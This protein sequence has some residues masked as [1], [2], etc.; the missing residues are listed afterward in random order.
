ME[1][2]MKKSL[3]LVS[4]IMFSSLLKASQN[5]DIQ[6]ERTDS[7]NLFFKSVTKNL[8]TL[9]STF[10]GNEFQKNITF[11]YGLFLN[12]PKIRKDLKEININDM[13]KINYGRV[14]SYYIINNINQNTISSENI[15]R[16]YNFLKVLENVSSDQSARQYLLNY[17][18]HDG[19][20]GYIKEYSKIISKLKTEFM[21]KILNKVTK[22]AIY[23]SETINSSTDTYLLNIIDNSKLDQLLKR[24]DSNDLKKDIFATY[25]KNTVDTITSNKKMLGSEFYANVTY[26]LEP[27]IKQYASLT[28]ESLE[29]VVDTF[30][31]KLTKFQKLLNTVKKFFKLPLTANLNQ[32]LKDRLTSLS[33]NQK[34]YEKPPKER[35][36]IDHLNRFNTT[37]YQEALDSYN[38]TNRQTLKHDDTIMHDTLTNPTSSSFTIHSDP[39]NN[40]SNDSNSQDFEHEYDSTH[41]GQNSDDNNPDEYNPEG[42]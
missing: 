37:M 32:T 39:V 35:E 1:S 11:T 34:N 14:L 18:G 20:N 19:D 9:N 16:L 15:N 4:C 31:P 24:I 22:N 3:L 41:T 21:N 28:N 33:S 5:T 7:L 10:T 2:E 17:E 25:I 38:K 13:D 8:I 30:I 36:N 40:D 26:G 23:K 29:T 42:K 27:A 6:L 12:N